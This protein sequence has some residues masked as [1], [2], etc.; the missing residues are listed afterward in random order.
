MQYPNIVRAFCA[1]P[2]AMLPEKLAALTEVVEIRA[3]GVKVPAETVAHYA[4]AAAARR[5]AT[6]SGTGAVAVIPIYGVISQRMDMMTEMSGGTSTEA[7]GAAFT[8][9]M[10]DPQVSAIVLDIDSPGGSVSGVPELAETIRKAR[11]EKPIIAVA[12]SLMAS[13][14]YWIGSAAEEVVASPSADVGSI[15]VYQ[16]HVDASGFYQGQ[17]LRHTMISAGKYKTEGNPY[18]P[19]DDDAR[20][21]MQGAVN[22]WYGLFTAAVAKH[23]DDTPAAVREGY[24]QGRVLTAKQAKAAGLVDRIATLDDVLAELASGKAR[25]GAG[26][27]ATVIVSGTAAALPDAADAVPQGQQNQ[28]KQ[29]DQP[30]GG[31]APVTAV[32]PTLDPAPQA[33]EHTVSHPNTAA[34]NGAAPNGAAAAPGA[35][36]RDRNAE[37]VEIFDLCAL[38]GVPDRA[39]GFI[40]ANNTPDQVR[41]TLRGERAANAQPAASGATPGITVGR[42]RAADRPWAS[43]G[44]QLHA[45]ARVGMGGTADPRLYA[46]ASGGSAASGPD[47]GF[48]I[49]PTFAQ[50]LMTSAFETGVL[51]ARCSSTE[52]GEN[53]DSLEVTYLS[54]TNRTTG[55]R[56]GGVRVY[57]V[58]EAETVGATKPQT[59][60]WRCELADMMGVAYMTERLL[61]DAPAMQSVFKE[62]FSSEMGYQLDAEIYDGTGVGQCLGIKRA[63]SLVTVSKV[64]AQAADTVV[65][66]NF[67]DMM[68]R[69]PRRW[70]A[71][72]AWYINQ[73]LESQL[74]GLYLA[75]GANSGQL[76]YMPP[77]GLS[78]QQYGTI[79]GAPV[80]PIEQAEAPGDLGDV[81]LAAL[82]QYKLITKGGVQE[83]ESIHVRF[84]YNER[85]FRWVSRVSG[86]PKQKEAITPAK[87]TK[88]LSAFVTLEAR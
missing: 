37:V 29:Q 82:S 26:R 49:H 40:S 62:S 8:S 3:S 84:L 86:A 78:G 81:T 64:N 31:E 32:V 11:G 5:A 20:E 21:A 55:N 1:Q 6:P 22:E 52:L 56:W 12:N 75:T 16:I 83:A 34:P 85:T 61:Q 76:V 51:A 70:R 47:G 80:I 13:A 53:S 44:E 7:V 71:G 38:A 79:L 42:D 58:A 30:T 60:K 77:G 24:G 46:A 19:L 69:M 68:A 50:D 9:A 15:G 54:D 87:G 72:A 73:E 43:L 41:E 25:R 14:A 18:E 35:P 10:R 74:P 63:G 57:R 59:D 27:A 28:P 88:K 39:A 4:T 33:E 65:A 23:R 48:L 17:G 66:Q 45:I 67:I 36:P 2:W